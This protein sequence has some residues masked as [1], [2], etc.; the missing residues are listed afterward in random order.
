MM[1]IYTDNVI[2][3]NNEDSFIG[4]LVIDDNN[5]TLGISYN[6]LNKIL[7]DGRDIIVRFRYNDAS[8]ENVEVF[9]LDRYYS[10][11]GKY[12]ASFWGNC[13]HIE[14]IANGP[15]AIFEHYPM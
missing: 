7:S 12:Y 1:N 15:D 11:E 14:Y 13:G 3:N 2:I 4:N 6:E 9:R 8:S 10:D 5:S